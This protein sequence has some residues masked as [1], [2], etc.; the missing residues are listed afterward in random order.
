M[1]DP[2]DTAKVHKLANELMFSGEQVSVQVIADTMLIEASDELG[3]QLELWWIKQESKVAFRR[4][5][6]SNHRHDVPETVYQSVQLIWEN[7]LKDVRLEIALSSKKDK[8]VG[9]DEIAMGDELH[10]AKSQLEAIEGSNQ[11]LRIKL[12]DSQ[13]DI[14]K[15]EAERAMLRSNLQSVELNVTGMNHKVT[16][17]KAEMQRAQTSSEE[18]KKQLDNRMKEEITRHQTNV[19]KIESKLGY[20]RHQLDKLR[21]DS[22][23]KEAALNSQLQ[24][25]QGVVARGTV[26][27]D[28]Q[29]SQIRSMD[30]ELRKFR[31]EITNQSRKMSQSNNQTLASKNRLKR[32][33]DTLLQREFDLKELKKRT[34]V[35]KSDTSRREADLRTLAKS[36]EVE[37]AELSNKTNEL[38][39][40]LIAREEEI[41]RLSAKL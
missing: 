30:E 27:Q 41:R 39:R 15:L 24:D 13:N 14:T 4:S 18:A 8:F 19:S 3:R 10:L 31:G 16:E 2:I 28:T 11:R 33:E 26:T 20:Y 17:S 37:Y 23:K 5:I 35:D 36:R 40:T 9:A 29:F 25:L 1:D 12:S 7:A 38:Q 34:I 6:S 22:G 21:D 32:L